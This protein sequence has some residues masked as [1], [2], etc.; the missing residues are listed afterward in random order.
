LYRLTEWARR[1]Q[2]DPLALLKRLHIARAFTPFQLSTILHHIAGEM[3]RHGATRLVITGFP[4]CLFDEELS[5]GEA[6]NTF[7]RCQAS[8]SRLSRMPYTILLFTDPPRPLAGERSRFLDS[9]AK[10][11]RMVLEVRNT[12]YGEFMPV[13]APGLLANPR[14]PE[15]SK[16]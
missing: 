14:T 16:R 10:Q 12:H 11:S 5:A 13:Q 9:L 4:D 2:I 8:L 1:K 6:H 3:E 7:D 15:E